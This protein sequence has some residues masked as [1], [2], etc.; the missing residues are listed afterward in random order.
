[1]SAN[2]VGIGKWAVVSG[3]SSG[4]GAATAKGLAKDGWGVVLLAR[5][6]AALEAVEREIR[7][8]GGWA[9]AI[10]TDAADGSAVEAA[11]N[12]IAAECGPVEL[13]VNAAG[14]GRWRF[15]EETS[16]E[17]VRTM[18]DAPFFAAFHLTRAFMPEMLRRA[19]GHVI[20]VNSPVSSMGW[21]GATGYMAARWA[22]RGLHEALC[23]DLVGTG[24]RSTH[25]VFGKTKSDYFVNNPGSEERLPTI[26]KWV[27]EITPERCAEVIRALVRRP[28]REFFYPFR[29]RVFARLNRFFPS[30]VRALSVRTGVRRRRGS[31]R[32]FLPSPAEEPKET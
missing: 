10:P 17:D 12:R 9:R 32:E 11:A 31:S 16:P 13:V 14:A 1:M 15:I 27:P 18:M 7:E 6:P 30:V 2:A 21:P 20:H 23:L 29:L 4:I 24:V 28:R 3:A 26:A 25:V 19:R 5:N 22:L 8:V